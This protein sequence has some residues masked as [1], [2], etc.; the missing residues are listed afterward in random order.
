MPKKKPNPTP[1]SLFHEL[2]PEERQIKEKKS[3]TDRL[4]LFEWDDAPQLETRSQDQ[5]APA[6]GSKS[7][8]ESNIR[9]ANQP[10]KGWKEP[11][12]NFSPVFKLDEKLV[13]KLN[14]KNKSILILRHA[15]K[16]LAESDFFRVGPKGEHIEGWTNGIIRGMISALTYV[17][18]AHGG[19]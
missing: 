15:S 17:T 9:S 10:I 14:A 3:E 13:G 12:T 18:C 2:F 16:T 4:P 1:L 7:A 6:P 11:A 8:R 19:F 5:K